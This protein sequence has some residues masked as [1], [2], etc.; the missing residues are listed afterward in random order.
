[1]SGLVVGDPIFFS[2][3]REG[4]GN[5]HQTQKKQKNDSSPTIRQV[6]CIMGG[7]G[8]RTLEVVAAR[9]LV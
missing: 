8:I 4:G 5:I 9:P 2:G 6:D 3:G 7:W 1:M